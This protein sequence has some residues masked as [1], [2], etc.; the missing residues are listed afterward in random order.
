MARVIT[1]S[2]VVEFNDPDDAGLLVAELDDFPDGLNQGNTSFVP[3]D[4]P[5]FLIYHSSN[6]II[7]SITPSAGFISSL[8]GG[9]SPELIKDDL[10]FT[11]NKSAS[12]SKPQKGSLTL[13]QL[14]DNHD[15]GAKTA[16]ELALSVQNVGVGVIRARYLSTFRKYRLG[17]I[18]TT[19]GGETE[20]Q[21]VIFVTGHVV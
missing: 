2:L 7:D 9:T 8:G 14:G 13:T 11:D 17:G 10:I 15:F 20:F 21:V 4:S 16:T 12:F 18:P 5:G 1:A 3:G 19:L 6:V